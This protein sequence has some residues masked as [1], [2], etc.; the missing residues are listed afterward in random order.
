MCLLSAILM[1][2]T[3]LWLHYSWRQ[4]ANATEGWD[5][6]GKGLGLLV[7]IG[8]SLLAVLVYPALGV[9]SAVSAFVRKRENQPRNW[10][11]VILAMT[12]LV[13]STTYCVIRLIEFLRPH[14]L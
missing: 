8:F 11:L 10:A 12:V 14:S 3:A 7:A 6:F 4:V 2:A 13:V 5:R 9:V 1:T